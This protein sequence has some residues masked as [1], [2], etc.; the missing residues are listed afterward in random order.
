MKSGMTEEFQVTRW[1]CGVESKLLE[2][3][4]ALGF[5]DAAMRVALSEQFAWWRADLGRHA[6]SV[7][8]D[9]GVHIVLSKKNA[10]RW[11]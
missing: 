6:E 4:R 9:R 3:I 5:T 10:C 1:Q 11:E 8:A 2:L 7:G